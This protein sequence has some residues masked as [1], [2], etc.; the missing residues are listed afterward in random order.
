MTASSALAVCTKFAGKV[1]SAEL[2][3]P[4]RL[5]RAKFSLVWATLPSANEHRVRR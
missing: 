3:K 2:G 4:P 5:V 1:C